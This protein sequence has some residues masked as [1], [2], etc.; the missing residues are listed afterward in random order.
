MAKKTN[1]ED[2]ANQILDLIGGKDNISFFTHCVT[3]LRFNLKDESLTNVKEIEKISGVV[4]SQWQSG[5]LQIIIGQSVGEAYKLISEKAG[6]ANEKSIEDSIEK[7]SKKKFSIN[8]IFDAITG[9]I[10]PIIPMLI[11]AGLLKVIILILTKTGLLSTESI[12]H[13]VLTFVSDSAFYYLPIFLGATAARKFNTNIGLGMFMGAILV[14]PTFVSLISEGSSL[15]LFGIPITSTSYGNTVIPIIMIVWI[16]SY[17]QRF[18]A[19]ISPEIIRSIV[20]PLGTAVVMIPLAL[21]VIGPLGAILGNYL[22][23]GLTFV[24][25]TT[26][27]FGVA[28]VSALLPLIV[29]T[30]MHTAFTPYWVAMFAKFGYEPFFFGAFIVSNINQGAAA[31]A[32]SLKARSNTLKSTATSTALTAIVAGVTEPALFGITLKYR[33]PLYAAM[34]G[35]FVGAG[36][37]GLMKVYCYAVVGSGGLFAIP[38]FIGPDSLNLINFLIGIAI[39]LIVT[40]VLT[41]ILGFKEEENV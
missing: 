13:T 22:S 10:A 2:L 19:R 29:L 36:Y 12:T 11:A 28:L 17:V 3:R 23:D 6:L 33:K 25:E 20:E 14:H 9:S 38:S 15:N 35:N 18:F 40:F 7:E 39:G 41:L 8:K 24:Y 30:G 16:M 5:Q 37:I 31:L 1:Y 32:V 21:T 26:G 27:F 34:I 4:G